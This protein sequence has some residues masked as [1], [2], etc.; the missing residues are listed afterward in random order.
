MDGI[1][2]D[3]DVRTSAGAK[4]P[5]A[6]YFPPPPTPRGPSLWLAR[7]A[8]DRRELVRFWPVIQNMVTQELRVRYQRSLLGFF[9]TLLNPLLML[10]TLSMVFST[11][12]KMDDQH[13][14]LFLL[15]GMVPWSLLSV[16][17][18]DCSICII[19]NEALIRKIYLPKLV[20]PLAR[21]LISL[22]TFVFTLGAMFL[23]VIPLGA[24]P[25]LSMLTLPVAIGLFAIFSL[26]LGLIVATANTFYRD[27]G[28]LI[29]VFLQAWY[30]VTPIIYPV[31]RFP[32]TSQWAFQLN[33]AYYFIELFHDILYSGQ[34]PRLGLWAASVVIAA[35]SLGVGYALF[36]SHEDKMVFRL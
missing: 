36:K 26:G 9:W 23:L 32:E 15:A 18:N 10:A 20:F 25:S 3:M 35:V 33:P 21:V 17:L 16:S 30:F 14:T 1:L 29:S 11:L 13:Y 24:R 34:W 4:V 8:E 6:E 7:L 22:V 5:H 27:C 28:H 2:P 31:T 12:F 19:N